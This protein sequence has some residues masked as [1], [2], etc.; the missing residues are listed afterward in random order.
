MALPSLTLVTGAGGFIGRHLVDALLAR[1][2]APRALVRNAAAA[3]NLRARGVEAL[4]GDVRDQAVAEA[5]VLGATVVFHCAAAVG[6]QFGRREIYDTNLGGVR[7]MLEAVR[8][9]RCA[10]ETCRLVLISS[11]NVLGTRHLDPATEDLPC[12]RSRD[13]AADVKIEAETLAMDYHRHHGVDVVI[14][15]PG[16]VYGPDD[17]HNVPRLVRAL[18]RGKF[19]FLGS[20]SNVVPI[21]HVR[22][23][24][25]AL[26]LAGEAPAASGR[27]YHITDGSR[28]TAGEFVGR[29]AELTG[30]P[31]PHKVLPYFVPWLGCMAFEWLGRLRLHRGP[32]P[33]TRAALRFL[34][35]SR[36]V[37]IRRAREELG[38]TPRV[39]YREGLADAVQ[40]IEEKTDGWV[41]ATGT[42]T[43]RP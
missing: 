18:R 35:T 43:P 29:L 38:Y 40:G 13:P 7:T 34:G 41:L 9:A 12:R 30:S 5:A 23:V 19:A 21:V 25:Q 11:V 36:Y 4:H 37:D 26:L 42:G 24:V 15:R 31:M 27:V 28:T 3:D 22:D 20:R 1:G 17:P 14:L 39:A 2:A 16:F 33:V 6:P 10:D 8:R 32:A